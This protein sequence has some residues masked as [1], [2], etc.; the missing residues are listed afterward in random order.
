MRRKLLWTCLFGTVIVI[1]GCGGGGG[2]GG[3]GGYNSPYNSPN[4]YLRTEVPYATPV[5]AATVDPLVNNKPNYFVGDTYAASISGSGQDVIIAGHMTQ[6]SSPSNWDSTRLSILSWNNGTLVDRTTQWFPDNSNI[7]TGTNSVKFADFFK[8]GRTDMVTAPYSDW[9]LANNGPAYVWTNTGTSFRRQAIAADVSAHDFAVADIN[10]DGYTDI[11]ILDAN[12][13]NSTLAINDRVSS[14]NT[15]RATSGAQLSGSSIAVADFLNNNTTTFITTDNWSPAGQVQKLWGWNIDAGNQL[16][17]TELGIL[18]TSRFN[19]PKWQAIGIL[20]SHNVRVSAHDFNSDNVTDAIV[21]S[22]PGRVAPGTST[23]YSE[24]QFLRNNG[25]GNFTDV[26]DSTLVGYN[27]NTRGTYNPKFLDLNGDGLTDILVSGG[28]NSGTSSQFLLKS[29]DGKYVASHASLL[30]DYLRQVKTMAGGDSN[31]HTVNVVQGPDGKMYLVSA[32]SVMNGSDRQLAVYVSALG[33][34]TVTTAQT[35]IDLIRQRWPYMTAAQANEA[36]ARTAAT[37][38]NGVAVI[39]EESIFKPVG[40]LGISTMRG[41]QP[42]TGFVAGLSLGD[43]PVVALD[44][45][46]RGYN[47]NLAPMSVNRLNAFGYNTQHNDQYE[48]TSHAEYLVNGA[49]TTVNGMRVG[50][51]FASRDSNALNQ[52]NRP[53][54]YTLGVPNWYKKGSWSV[55]TQYTYLNSNPWIAFG[56]AWG[57]VTGSGIMDNV[58]TYRNRGFS[59]QAS[60]MHV[61]TNITPGLI[62]KVNNMWGTWAETG[63]R[64]GDVRREGNLGMYAGIKPVVMSGSVEARLPTSVD[65]AGNVVY[66]NRTLNVQNQSIGYVRALYTNQLDRK[67]QLRLSAVSTTTGQYRAMTELRFWID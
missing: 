45:L 19:L 41:M 40:S 36:L 42:I 26:T 27:T 8:S 55:G 31:N 12:A 50:S 61:T 33:S 23:N 57:S 10:R 47:L 53:T 46:G 21:F 11:V 24:I 35:A 62:T 18:P 6:Q 1:T 7:I 49:V 65:N 5:R 52:M 30:T 34:Q 67:T 14:F 39:D 9:S 58:V 37:Y 66:T 29:R 28:D 20:D 63:Y 48:M 17:F 2:G 25:G 16:S 22:Q 51:D 64:F 32:V 60:A 59:A 43:A 44:Q 13:R 15:Y 56:G 3:G 38:I 54:Q 4:P